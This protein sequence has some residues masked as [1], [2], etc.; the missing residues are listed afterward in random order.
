MTVFV[1]VFV[2]VLAIV[3]IPMLFGLGIGL[4]FRAVFGI[5]RSGRGSFTA[6]NP[7]SRRR[8]TELDQ[9]RIQNE[10]NE[11]AAQRIR[12]IPI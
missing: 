1:I 8:R 2:L 11:A 9:R 6:P 5:F 12:D 4:I 3:F 10:A 7:D